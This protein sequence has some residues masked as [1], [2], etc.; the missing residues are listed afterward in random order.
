MIF[1]K[2][3]EEQFKFFEHKKDENFSRT[4]SSVILHTTVDVHLQNEFVSPEKKMQ[5]ILSKYLSLLVKAS[6]YNFYGSKVNPSI[7]FAPKVPCIY[8]SIIEHS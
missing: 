7:L 1:F 6:R 2:K 5:I 8:L 4:F 3:T